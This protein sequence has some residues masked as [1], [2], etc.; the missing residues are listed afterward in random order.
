[1]SNINWPTDLLPVSYSLCGYA[2]SSDYE[3]EGLES[4]SEFTYTLR[5]HHSFSQKFFETRIGL[6]R[7]GQF[8]RHNLVPI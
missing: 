6:E 8:T 3:S 1:M 4:A 2:V 7:H 5:Y